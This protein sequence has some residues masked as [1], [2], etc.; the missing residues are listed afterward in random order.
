[1]D[2]KERMTQL[3]ETGQAEQVK[4][5]IYLF[6]YFDIKN[7]Y[8]PITIEELLTMWGVHRHF[9]H[10]LD[11]ISSLTPDKETTSV[12][13]QWDIGTLDT[14]HDEQKMLYFAIV[15]DD[16]H[17]VMNGGVLFQHGLMSFHT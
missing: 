15:A 6:D 16:N 9:E 7:H 8:N 12:A 11:H 3:I 1:M 10:M 2:F 17:L 4:Q 5:N 14:N 13:V